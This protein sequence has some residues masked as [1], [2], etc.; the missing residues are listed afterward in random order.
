[1]QEYSHWFRDKMCWKE[2]KINWLREPSSWVLRKSL[3]KMCYF[4]SLAFL[5]LPSW[6]WANSLSFEDQLIWFWEQNPKISGEK[7]YWSFRR[8]LPK[9]D[10]CTKRWDLP[11]PFDFFFETSKNYFLSKSSSH[12]LFHPNIHLLCLFCSFKPIFFENLFLNKNSKSQRKIF[13]YRNSSRSDPS[14]N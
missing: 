2:T 12:L 7:R 4:H 3:S 11:L 14:S 13:K 9:E 8:L 5:I 10:K 1:M 6:P